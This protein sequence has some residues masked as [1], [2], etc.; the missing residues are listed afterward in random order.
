MIFGL[1]DCIS[2][3]C[4][5]VQVFKPE[6]KGK[7]V[8]VLSNNDGAIVSLTKEAKK[9]DGVKRG[10]PIFTIKD[11]V[12][13]N[14]INVFSSNYSL[15]ED[16]SLRVFHTLG[17]FT[18][19]IERYSIDEAFL[20]FKGYEYYDI[21]EYAKHIVAVTI[22]NTGIPV[23]MGLAH[24]KTLSKVANKLSKSDPDCQGVKS[25]L[26]KDEIAVGLKDFPIE[27]VWGIGG[28][29]AALLHGMG[30]RTAS[31]FLK[32]NP[33]WIKKNMNITGLR[34]WHELQ[35]KSCIPLEQIPP[36]KKGMCTSRSFGKLMTACE[37]ISE[38]IAN[39][40]AVCARKLRAQHSCC[41]TMKV[42]IQTHPFRMDLPQYNA[43]KLIVFDVPTNNTFEIVSKAQEAFSEIFKKGYHYKKAGIMVMDIIPENQ[44]QA[45]FFDI[46]DREKQSKV[47]NA[48]DLINGRLGHDV[49]RLGSQGYGG[50]WKLKSDNL[51]PN[52]TTQMND[53]IQII[54]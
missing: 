53:L 8:V 41:K 40:G 46:V 52:Y 37:P 38:A 7:P 4:S 21:V 35:G 29:Y 12:K 28:R 22:K 24:T 9:I 30:I 54:I 18:P 10:V 6:L 26:S 5:V 50:D 43:S 16:I 14:K 2:Y 51:P 13:Q 3:Y 33:E 48:L 36:G 1:V 25:L 45:N 34:M 11:I 49:V 23:S 20:Q 15:F 27:D 47:M 31:Q 39:Y 32:L 42:F 44:V 19:E 17:C